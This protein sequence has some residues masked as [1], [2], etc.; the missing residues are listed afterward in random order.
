MHINGSVFCA[1]QNFKGSHIKNQQILY[2]FTTKLK[3]SI[4]LLIRSKKQLNNYFLAIW[5]WTKHQKI[6][7]SKFCKP[8]FAENRLSNSSID[9]WGEIHANIFFWFF[10]IDPKLLKTFFFK[11]QLGMNAEKKSFDNLKIDPPS[12]WCSFDTMFVYVSVY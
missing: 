6:W 2:I 5:N 7:C 4:M 9:F 8:L 10:K 1:F 11:S 3:N 12:F